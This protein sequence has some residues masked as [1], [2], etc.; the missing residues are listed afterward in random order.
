M[1]RYDDPVAFMAGVRRIMVKYGLTQR[2]LAERAGVP[3]ESLTRW[4]RG[5]RIPTRRSMEK[6]QAAVDSILFPPHT[7]RRRRPRGRPQS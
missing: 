6:V 2:R 1:T 3:R 4:L 7:G 5:H